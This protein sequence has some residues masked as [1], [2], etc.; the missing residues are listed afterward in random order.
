MTLVIGYGSSL[1]TDDRLGP[2]LARKLGY[3]WN[4]ITR[5]QLTPELVEP[6]GQAKR[7]VI[8]DACIGET[9]GEVACERVVPLSTNGAF[10]HN[11]TPTS[12]LAAAHELYGAEPEVILITVTGASFDYG[13]SFS[14]QIRIRLPQIIERVDEIITAFFSAAVEVNG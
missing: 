5:T 6:V 2:Y 1:R 4:A 12:L 3:R 14:P 13:C 8:I 9:P 7:V 11:V 10:T